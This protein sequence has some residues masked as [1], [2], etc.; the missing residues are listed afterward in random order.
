MG[1]VMNTLKCH[2]VAAVCALALPSLAFSQTNPQ[3]VDQSVPL[4]TGATSSRPIQTVPLVVTPTQIVLEPL[5]LTEV[6]QN[7]QARILKIPGVRSV[8][9]LADAPNVL[10]LISHNDMSIRLDNLLQRVNA[11][12]AN[13]EAEFTRFENNIKSL[14]ARTDPFKPEQLRVVIRKT[15]AINTFET[16]TAVDGITNIVV[17]RPFMDDLEEVVVGDTPTAIALMPATRLG[18][19]QMTAEQAFERA[20]AN[21]AAAASNI[22]WRTLN[23]LNEVTIVNGYETSLLALDGLWPQLVRRLGGPLAVI[24]PTRQKLVI[25]RADRP[26]D[27]ARLRAIASAEAIGD[28][29][30]S[31]KVW[32]RRG[33]VWVER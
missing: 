1:I 9:P 25:G 16:E 30:L 28:L 21:T 32:V 20:R 17:R 12:G 3:P 23:G 10:R 2:L 5:T 31:G 13:R 14:L 15:A 4:P 27:I 18:D 8:G 11:P 29:A 26:R 22:S 33:Q 24:V 6:S 19:L 7:I